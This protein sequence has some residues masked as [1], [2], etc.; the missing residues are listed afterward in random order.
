M[1]Q[2]TLSSS[3]IVTDMQGGGGTF[4]LGSSQFTYS[5]PG[6]T[7]VWSAYAPGSE[8][9]SSYST[10]NAAQ[11]ANF[12]KAIG[13]WDELIAPNFTHVADNASGSGEVRVAFTS[14]DAGT[15]GYAYSGTPTTPGGQVGDVWLNST[16][17]GLTY[18]SGTYGFTTMLHELGHTLGLKH[19]FE[20][21]TLPAQYDNTRFTVMAYDQPTDGLITTFTS[22]GGGGISS[23]RDPIVEVTPM[24]ID[25][26]AV[27]AI[28]GASTT[29]RTG[30]DIYAYGNSDGNVLRTI[31]DA[32]GNDTIDLSA[33]TRDCAIDLHAGA[34]S[35]IAEWSTADQ[36][37]YWEAKYPGADSFI[38]SQFDANSYQWH[39]NLGIA[40]NTVIENANGGSADDSILGNDV[41]NVLKGN[42]GNDTIQGL[43]G[44][45]TLDGGAGV[46]K[47]YGGTGNDTYHVDTQSDL[48]FENPGEGTDTVN[49]SAGFYLYDNIENL[50]LDAGAGDIFGVGNA[51]ANTM[52]GNEGANL[53]I[54]GGG[55]DTVHGGAGNDNLY[56]Q[57]GND[58]LYGD[59]GIDYLVGGIGNDT[60]DGGAGPDA[61][62]GEDGNDTL[63]GGTTFDTDILVGGNGDDVLHGDSGL[64]DYDR[65]DGGPGNDSYYVDTGD[66]LTFEAAGGGTDTV[67]ANVAGANN[68]VYLYANVENLVL[69]GTTTFGVGNELA[70]V[71]TGN[72]SGNW[73]LGGDGNDTIN[74]K[75]GNDVLFGQGG[76]DTFVFEHGTGGDV[77]GDFTHGQDKIDVH[78]FGFASFAALQASFHQVG[79]DGA[80]DLGGGDLVVL[81]HTT[82]TSLDA[83]DFAL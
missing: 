6:A 11:A 45:D 27:Q 61:L 40:L 46:D 74:G 35:S 18:D 79:G 32:G 3:T 73:L 2:V 58:T 12:V 1:T 21:P 20:T 62:Y 39:D 7:S 31:Y 26:A 60:L 76:N 23:E 59:A 9:F 8:P 25:I 82:M 36:I 67:Y 10:L 70:N 71:L 13:L 4:K 15:A 51:L 63:W 65:M 66:D 81:Q 16:D 43:A 49:A 28:Y 78:A 54:A 30:N 69:L 47:L 33:C 68:G 14:M 48:V 52:A 34:Y 64:G 50:T 38:S 24:V 5:I 37:A 22:T 80:I 41:N 75:A 44:N 17:T 53:L 56:G 42:A 83:G 72:A 55:D 57:D 19:P 29:T 77:I